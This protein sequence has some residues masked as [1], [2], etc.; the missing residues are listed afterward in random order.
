VYFQPPV[1]V[2]NAFAKS[3][4]IIAISFFIITK[5]LVRVVVAG[6]GNY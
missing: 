5:Q 1:R 3:S 4:M 2:A 6:F